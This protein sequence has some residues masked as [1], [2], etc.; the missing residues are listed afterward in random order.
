M[1]W[2]DYGPDDIVKRVLDSDRLKNGAIILCH[3]GA[4][5]TPDA[6]PEMIDGLSKKGYQVVPVS[7]LVLQS[8]YR[9]DA[10]GRQI[11]E[12]SFR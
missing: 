8:N 4:R 11:P 6:L 9:M 12:D 10:E 5:C 3:N 7:E 1:D 2:K